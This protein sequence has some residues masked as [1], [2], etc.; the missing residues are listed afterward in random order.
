[1]F[2]HEREKR[3]LETYLRFQ[4]NPFDADYGWKTSPVRILLPHE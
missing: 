3:R 4:S 2:N 1:M